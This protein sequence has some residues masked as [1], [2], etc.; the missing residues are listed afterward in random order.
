ME[1]KNIAFPNHEKFSG[2]NSAY[3]D[4]VNKIT[5]VINCLAPY[6]TIRVKN[7]SNE[8]FYGELAEQITNRDKLF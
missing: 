1:K 8:W 6:K 2:I 4:L 5:Q 3:S 7:Y